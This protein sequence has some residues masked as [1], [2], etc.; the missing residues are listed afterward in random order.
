[1]RSRPNVVLLVI[2][3]L[4]VGLAVIAAVVSANRTTPSPDLAT[5]EGV[6]QAYVV[7]VIDA[8]QE[9]MESFLDPGLGCKAPF[10]YF[11]PPQAASLALVSSRT[12]GS[13]ATVVVE[14]TEGEGRG[15]FLGGIYTH[16][17]NFTLV[18]RNDRW[19]ISGNPWPIYECKGN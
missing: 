6:V 4:V 13:T 8:D 16:R 18:S 9:K 7:A 5:P 1:M 17:E 2:A 15:P 3:A 12:S 19:L 10:P 11:S 14:I